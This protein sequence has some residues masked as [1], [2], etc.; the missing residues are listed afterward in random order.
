MTSNVAPPRSQTGSV[1]RLNM[2]AQQQLFPE[3]CPIAEAVAG[4]AAAG[5]EARG[6]VFTRLE[7]VEF[8]LDL[9]GYTADQPLQGLRLLEPSF[10]AGDF[11]LPAL[12]RLL[13]ALEQTSPLFQAANL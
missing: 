12:Q 9:A 3:L 8:I 4:M 7:V 2:S 1:S 11:F 13:K 10:G 5:A 6:A